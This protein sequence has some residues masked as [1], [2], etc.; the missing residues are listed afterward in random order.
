MLGTETN[1]DAD[2]RR[3]VI[4]AVAETL[5]H[6]YVFPEKRQAMREALHANLASGTYGDLTTNVA[7]CER[8]TA[9][10]QTIS[11][12]KHIRVRLNEEP[13]PVV[14]PE[15]DAPANLPEWIAE[16]RSVNFG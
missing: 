5:D 10:L 6:Y 11:S 4:E 16:A 13:R 1:L 14:P 12:D 3:Q 9:D 7:L 2:T 8:L 15:E